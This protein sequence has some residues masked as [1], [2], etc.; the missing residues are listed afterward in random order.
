MAESD[1]SWFKIASFFGAGVLMFIAVVA[2]ASGIYLI[3]ENRGFNGVMTIVAGIVC[4]AASVLIYKNYEK[5]SNADKP[6]VKSK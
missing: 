1:F 5:K 2:V 3:C 6:G 4:A